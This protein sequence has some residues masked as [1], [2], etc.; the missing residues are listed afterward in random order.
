MSW[1]LLVGVA[2]LSMASCTEATSP[3]PPS[4][5][6][7][8]LEAID[9]HPLPAATWA[10]AT[11]TSMVVWET[12]TLDDAGRA[13]TVSHQRYVSQ[14]RPAQE[15]TVSRVAAYRVQGDSIEVG[16]FHACVDLCPPN[17]VGQVADS[18]LTLRA[19]IIDVHV[20]VFR[21]RL[22]GSY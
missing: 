7:Y 10:S 13:V 17:A 5:R 11:D 18:T 20:P 6:V 9:D 21:Y 15:W 12:L 8:A 16:W 19:K 3:P 2:A 22:V 4:A 1:S 14:G